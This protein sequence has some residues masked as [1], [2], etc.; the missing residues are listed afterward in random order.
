MKHGFV[1]VAAVSPELRVADPAFNAE[2]IIQAIRD[3]AEAGTEILVFPE[4]SLCGYTCG[5]LLL[6]KT[7]LDGCLDALKRVSEATEGKKMLVF[8]GLPFEARDGKLYNC[9][10]TVAD[11]KT[12]AL[13]PKS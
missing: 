2:K 11:G 6:Q 9:A 1:K 3:Q 5:D 10:A 12:E 4:L 7:L 8:V 13:I